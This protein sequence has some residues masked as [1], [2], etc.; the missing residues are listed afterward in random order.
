MICWGAGLRAKAQPPHRC[1]QVITSGIID[2]LL[3]Y[4]TC[5]PQGKDGYDRIERGGRLLRVLGR[6]CTVVPS[7]GGLAA[8]LQ[9]SQQ[10]CGRA[11][12]LGEGP[13]GRGGVT[14]GPLP[15]CETAGEGGGAEEGRGEGCAMQRPSH[16]H[17]SAGAWTPWHL[18]GGP[19]FT[20]AAGRPSPQLTPHTPCPMRVGETI[21]G[22]IVTCC[23]V[24]L[25]QGGS[26][27]NH[28]FFFG[29]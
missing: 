11:G 15:T 9:Q 8:T 27:R 14:P 26:L 21:E 29:Q 10:V 16:P 13:L 18:Y 12:P 3:F 6:T 24:C 5:K 17:L 19:A 1:P 4:L 25:G 22:P 2:A 23:G 7:D 28:L 20:R